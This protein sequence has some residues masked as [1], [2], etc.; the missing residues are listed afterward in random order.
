MKLSQRMTENLMVGFGLHSGYMEMING[1][2]VQ[3]GGLESSAVGLEWQTKEFGLYS[4]Y[5]RQPVH[6]YLYE[7]DAELCLRKMRLITINSLE[8]RECT[9]IGKPIGRVLTIGHER[10]KRK[11]ELKLV[12]S[13]SNEGDVRSKQMF[14]ERYCDADFSLV[15]RG[16][17]ILR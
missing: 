8:Q 17:R 13:S 14:V 1:K 9:R 5:S 3:K 2:Y 12:N 15:C 11:K 10:G 6:V 16:K 7:S 4:T